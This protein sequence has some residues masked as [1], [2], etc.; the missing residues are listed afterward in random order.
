MSEQAAPF[1]DRLRWLIGHFGLNSRQLALE[2]KANPQTI[3]RLLS[4]SFQPRR[5]TL[6][7]FAARWPHMSMGWLLTGAGEAFPTGIYDERHAAPEQ[8]ERPAPLPPAAGRAKMYVSH[9]SADPADLRRELADAQAELRAVK[10]E[11][12]LYLRWLEEGRQ[13]GKQSGS[14]DSA[15]PRPQMLHRMAPAACRAS[16]WI[17]RPQAVALA[18]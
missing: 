1:A 15:S 3:H 6:D 5:S 10:T 7:L 11:R 8:P 13:L 12:D 2:V 9:P 4:G 16:M 18:G 17:D 14:A